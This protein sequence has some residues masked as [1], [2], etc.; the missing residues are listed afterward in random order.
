MAALHSILITAC[1]LL[2]LLTPLFLW[3]AW[4]QWA[5]WLIIAGGCAALLIIYVLIWTSP[6]EYI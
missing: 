3:V 6:D 1:G 2:A 4:S 5:F